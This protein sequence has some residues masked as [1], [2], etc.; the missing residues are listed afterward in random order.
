MESLFRLLFRL[1]CPSRILVVSNPRSFSDLRPKDCV[2][3]VEIEVELLTGRT[4]QIRGQLSTEGFPLVGDVLYG[5]AAI[6]SQPSKVN[7]TGYS[8]GYMNSEH[9]ALQCCE[10]HFPD[11]DYVLNKKG[12][13][14]GVPSDRMNRFRLDEAWWTPLLRGWTQDGDGGESSTTSA[15]DRDIVDRV[16]QRGTPDARQELRDYH[17]PERIQL[18]PG[19]NKYVL[20][21]AS[22]KETTPEWFVISAA[23]HECGGAYHANVAECVVRDLDAAGYHAVIVGGGRIDYDPEERHAHVYGFSYGFGKGDHELASHLIE[24]HSSSTASYDD[25]DG[26]Y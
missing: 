14:V 7:R 24:K 21:K 1:S 13:E 2:G 16:L 11:P 6:S 10:L 19:K 3:V 9:L 23:P 15:E 17:L 20:I 25:S 26:L 5:G 22:S 4:H 8:D 12:E 18:S